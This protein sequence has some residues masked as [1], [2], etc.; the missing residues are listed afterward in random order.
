MPANMGWALLGQITYNFAQ[1]VMIFV[2][3]RL[4]G[5]GAVGILTLAFSISAP[6]IMFS[7]LRMHLI[8]ASDAK[9]KHIFSDYFSL[10]LLTTLISLIIIIFLSI[11]L[12]QGDKWV[13]VFIGC[14]KSFEAISDIFYA[15]IQ[16]Y[17]YNK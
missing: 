11:Y 9:H 8:L 2:L 1:W 16:K 15:L 4:N 10:R 7:N 3:T 12:Y 6:I 13:V 17:E 14:A 5:V